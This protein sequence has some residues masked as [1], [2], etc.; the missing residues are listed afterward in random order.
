M[1]T[2]RVVVE[3]DIEWHGADPAMVQEILARGV[4]FTPEELAGTTREHH[5]GSDTEPEMFEVRFEPNTVV[6]AHAH[7]HDEIIY[8]VDG[9]MILGS[10]VL[11]PGSSVFLAGQTLY[12]FRAGPE[13][14]HFVNF[15]PQ[16]GAGYLS[17]DEFVAQ[18]SSGAA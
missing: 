11:T 1:G 4:T 15:R 3:K 10:R 5:A 13:G 2:V 7:I 16:S 14:L 8:V 9:E 17:K 18:R 6:Q 12:S